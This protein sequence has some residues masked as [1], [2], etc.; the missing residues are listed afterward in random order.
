[1]ICGTIATAADPPDL[2]MLFSPPYQSGADPQQMIWSPN[3]SLIAFLW[4][5]QGE[6]F[7]NLWVANP[8][9][10]QL[11]RLTS[12]NPELNLDF[13][14][15]GTVAWLTNR[16]LCFEFQGDI[17]IAGLLHERTLR[18]IEGI[19]QCESPVSLSPNRKYLTYG[20]QGAL[21]LYDLTADKAQAVL[22]EIRIS[23]YSDS[24]T[25]L[26]ITDYRWSH[27]SDRI[28]ICL[29]SDQQDNA[30]R[31]KIVNV[32]NGAQ[33]EIVI[34]NPPNRLSIVRNF[35]WSPDDQNLVFESVSKNLLE[36]CLVL[37]DLIDSRMDTLYREIREN[38][39]A[40]FGYQLYWIE[41]EAKILFG[42]ENNSFNH[43]YTL[44]V[45]TGRYNA[46]TRGKWNV[47]NYT[48]DAA[49]QTVYFTGTKD[50]PDQLQLYLAHLKTGEIAPV[51]YRGGDYRFRLSNSGQ[52]IVEVFS[53]Q[54]TP[55]ELYWIEA[56]PQSK[57]NPITKRPLAPAGTFRNKLPKSGAAINPL[58]GRLINY[59]MWLPDGNLV[60]RKYPVI[61]VLNGIDCVEVTTE[62]W[63]PD[64]FFYQILSNN[65]YVVVAIEYTDLRTA[66]TLTVKPGIQDPLSVQLS[67][68]RAV[69]DNIGKLDYVDLARA[70]ICGWG[71]GGYLATMAMFK[72]ATVFRTGF[73]VTSALE[74][75][76]PESNYL[77]Y[78]TNLLLDDQ[79]I[80]A[81]IDPHKYYHYLGGRFLMVQ[82]AASCLPELI[83][84]NRLL[85]ELLARHKKVDFNLYPWESSTIRKSAD[86]YDLFRK[87]VAF[88]RENL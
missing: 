49:G 45:E 37:I 16:S 14:A 57:M 76:H 48:I 36:R 2:Q 86:Q 55:P 84:A 68:L 88:F 18:R 58:T 33:D 47:R 53:D 74:W 80:A 26:Q 1:M 64:I 82:G 50:R 17:W 10:G 77:R 75:S 40:D 70:G 67:D 72:E 43:L 69:L 7:R 38:R 42:I 54:L 34:K 41:P 52:K 15:I 81:D 28:A 73:A 66:A 61:I 63:R 27:R 20:R 60:A 13:P 29:A 11:E 78:L 56:A 87:A 31:F 5:D 25:G 85:P 65:G 19:S 32:T 22:P 44:E 35:I 79:Q 62:A 8:L 46:L 12:F 59:R 51:S 83:E 39:V 3:D 21:V 30:V 4:N 6:E 24:R 71:Y 23:G 9:T